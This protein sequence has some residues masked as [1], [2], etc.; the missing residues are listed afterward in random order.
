[1]IVAVTGLL[2]LLVCHLSVVQPDTSSD[3]AA[4][5]KAP[6]ILQ[7]SCSGKVV[8][9]TTYYFYSTETPIAEC[10]SGM[11]QIEKDFQD[12]FTFLDD[13]S[14][15]NFSMTINS[16]V[17][18][19]I[20]YYKCTCDGKSVSGLQLKVYDPVVVE[21]FEGDNATLPC[22]GNTRRD[23][24]DIQWMKDG[25]KLPVYKYS[26][27]GEA[28]AGRIT[29]SKEG[30]QTG[31][32]SL[33]IGAVRHSDA[34]LYLCLIHQGSREGDPR[35]VLLKVKDLFRKRNEGGDDCHVA[36]SRLR[37]M[38]QWETGRRHSRWEALEM[39]LVI[40]AASP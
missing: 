12:R 6:L 37:P 20:G 35:A 34:S 25:G 5:V 27:A 3:I 14:A 32:L 36:V 31:D 10:N 24:Q 22:Y 38:W 9:W 26:I 1:M 28:A 18:N 11:C 16:T 30:F 13:T 7:C 21:V 2:F 33:R 8:K 39:S 40:F 29:M 4:I 17:Y 23:A 15:G 19:D